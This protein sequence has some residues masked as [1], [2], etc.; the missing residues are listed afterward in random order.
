MYRGEWNTGAYSQMGGAPTKNAFP[1]GDATKHRNELAAMILSKAKNDITEKESKIAA[2]KVREMV[3]KKNAGVSKTTLKFHQMT[4]AEIETKAVLAK[5][6]AYAKA[7]LKAK[8]EITKKA[9]KEVNA[10][11]RELAKEMFGDAKKS[12]QKGGGASDGLSEYFA[13]Y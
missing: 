7:A 9:N 10:Y 11:K 13:Q 2:T 6:V 3:G 5:Y 8:E 12:V 4:M 1:A